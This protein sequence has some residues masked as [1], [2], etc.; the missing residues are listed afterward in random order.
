MKAR[1]EIINKYFQNWL[2]GEA[3]DFETIF[4]KDI[5]YSECYGP[6]YEG[7][8]NIKRWFNSWQVNG[9]VLIWDIKQFIHKGNITVAEWYFKCKYDEEIT[10]FNGVSIIEFNKENLIISIKEFQSKIPH[11][12]PY[13]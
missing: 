11:Y 9:K 8:D 5:Y 13:K 7:L 4:H 1:E 10:E 12:N 2:E 3:T 6:E